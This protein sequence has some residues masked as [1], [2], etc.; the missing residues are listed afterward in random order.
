MLMKSITKKWT[1]NYNLEI[2]K[3]KDLHIEGDYKPSIWSIYF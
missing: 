1:E 3:K 2:I